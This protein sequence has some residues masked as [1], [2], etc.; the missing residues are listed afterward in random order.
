MG[1]SRPVERVILHAVTNRVPRRATSI[2]STEKAQ[3]TRAPVNTCSTRLAAVYG[4]LHLIQR[5]S[6]L[7]VSDLHFGSD[8]DGFSHQEMPR[9]LIRYIMDVDASF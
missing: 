1:L 7:H 8:R 4:G 2:A 6:W 5:L 3:P 9:A